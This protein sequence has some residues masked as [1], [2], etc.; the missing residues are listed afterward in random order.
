MP[1]QRDWDEFIERLI[2]VEGRFESLSQIAAEFKKSNEELRDDIEE[3][4]AILRKQRSFIGG[5]VF[6]I[7]TLW[8]VALAAYEVFKHGA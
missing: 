1:N 4:K 7:S 6:A 2:R 3:M 8:A 5:V